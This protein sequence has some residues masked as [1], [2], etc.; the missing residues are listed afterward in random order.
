[1][2][3]V[4]KITTAVGLGFAGVSSV[5]VGSSWLESNELGSAKGRSTA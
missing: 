1:M 5:P 3:A 2:L 4:E